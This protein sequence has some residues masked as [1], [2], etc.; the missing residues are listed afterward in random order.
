M[1]TAKPD[2]L[3][4]I[5]DQQR[6]AVDMVIAGRT[7][8]EIATALKIHRTTVCNWR[9][10]HAGFQG[11]LNSRRAE[12]RSAASERL[13]GL[14]VNAIGVLHDKLALKDSDGWRIALK[15]LGMFDNLLPPDGEADAGTILQSQIHGKM[16]E[17]KERRHRY[18][19]LLDTLKEDEDPQVKYK[20]DCEAWDYAVNE[21]LSEV[22]PDGNPAV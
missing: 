11:E 6:Q 7:D 19:H 9:N 14:L 2:S 10:R 18:M 15:L 16:Q 1:T 13:H 17:H 20:L 5:N 3:L 4:Q 8:G 22:A 12:L 21:L